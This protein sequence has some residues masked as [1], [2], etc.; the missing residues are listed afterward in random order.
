MNALSSYSLS[1]LFLLAVACTSP[2]KIMDP[3]PPAAGDPDLP[4]SGDKITVSAPVVSSIARD[5][6]LLTAS[7]TNAG[8]EAVISRGFYYSLVDPPTAGV[9]VA[10]DDEGANRF[11]ATLDGLQENTL[12]FVAASVTTGT[13]S[14][15]GPADLFRTTSNALA[16]YVPPTYSDDYSRDGITSWNN[17]SRWNLANVHDPTVEKCGEYYYMYT[18]DASYGNVHEGRGHFPYRRS[19]DLVN[20]EFLGMAMDGAPAWVKDSLNNIRQRLGLAAI[21]NPVLLYWAPVVRRVGDKYRMYYSIP[22]DNY[23]GNGLPNTTANFDNTW[24]ERAFIGLMET[25]DLATNA[26]V[27]KGMVV[28]SATDR[29]RDWSRSS[30]SNWSAYFKWNAIDPSFI[31][32]RE[33]KHWLV[34]G[35]WHSGIVALELDPATGLPARPLVNDPA[36]FGTRVARRTN[37]DS[38]RWQAQEAPEIVYNPETGY[39][40]LFLAYDELSVAY[41]TRVCRATSVEGPYYGYNGADV[42]AGATCLPILTHP[43]RFN[44]HSGWVG[45]SHCCVFRDPDD[46]RW[47]YASQGRLPENTGGNAYSNAIMMGHVREI[48]WTEDGWPV[49]MP[50]RYAGVPRES[51]TEGELVG[52]WENIILSYSAGQQRTASTVVLAA[53]KSASGA[54]TGTWAYDPVTGILSLGTYR[55]HL[56]RGLD[57]EADP[58]VPT[59]VYA[60]IDSRGY[61]V[62]GKKRN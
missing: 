43:Y 37:S 41:N 27:D 32:D 56:R 31:I 23:I 10:A 24:T 35:S 28:Y 17:R 38:N 36:D 21:N 22:V 7:F 30:L 19:R 58:R 12:Y 50:E 51:I 46:G 55:L 26:W 13:R 54:I 34:Y 9:L 18:T 61:S 47:Y 59:L 33:G 15:T 53:D 8:D 44:D 49:V 52:T 60:G 6:A 2:E 14:V 45:I 20:W 5:G 39:Y 29:G 16:T 48:L 57:W 11:S 25:D 3:L 42:T 4:A 1:S 40:Y 62:W